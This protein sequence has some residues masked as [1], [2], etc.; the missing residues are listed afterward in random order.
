MEN[1]TKALILAGEILI[2][3][4]L[5]TLMVFMFRAMGDFSNAVDENI[6]TKNRLEFNA[7]FE[8]YWNKA[9]ITAQDIVSMG[10]LA[11]RYNEKMQNEEL[12]ILVV[13]VSSKYQKMHIL[14]DEQTYDFIREYSTV[15]KTLNSQ[16]I[17]EIRHFQC[18]EM[19]YHKENGKV[20]RI[21]LKKLE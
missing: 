12:E 19:T 1:A 21:V 11:K 15:N 13:G 6:E 18:I 10:N 17:S 5:L 7:N 20:N 3:V 8:K 16:Q 14:K 4:I 9:D 2:G